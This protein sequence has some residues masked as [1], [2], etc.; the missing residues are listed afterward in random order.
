MHF[1][2]SNLKIKVQKHKKF[3]TFF[4]KKKSA[5]TQE[6]MH[7]FLIQVTLTKKCS[8]KKNYNFSIIQAYLPDKNYLNLVLINILRT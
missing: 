1:H 8:N 3:C 5:K 7:I 6:F 2:L 4:F